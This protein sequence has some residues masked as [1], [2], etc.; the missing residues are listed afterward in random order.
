MT[1]ASSASSVV[2]VVLERHWGTG[3]L[4]KNEPFSTSSFAS[5]AA[6]AASVR[7]VRAVGTAC[8]RNPV[9]VVVPCH[10]VVRSDGSVGQYLGGADMK[11]AL[12]E[13]ER[14]G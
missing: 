12:L 2:L 13:M 4:R 14:G 10:R 5:V 11:A 6:A 3:A 8:A 1:A 7:A 9:P